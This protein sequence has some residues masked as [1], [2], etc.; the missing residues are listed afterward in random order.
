MAYEYFSGGEKIVLEPD[1]DLVAVRFVEP[2]LYSVR[3]ATA[4]KPEIDSF[5]NR[6]EVPE[7]KFTILNVAK[8]PVPR[9]DR[10]RRAVDAM[11]AEIQVARVTPVFKVGNARVLATDRVRVGFKPDTADPD[12]LIVDGGYE[13]LERYQNEYTIRIKETDDPFEVCDQFYKMAEVEYAEPD[14]VTIKAHTPTRLSGDDP[15]PLVGRQYAARITK[16]VE[17][18][19]LVEGCP[20][21]KIAILDE[22]VDTLHE[23]LAAA[24]VGSYDAVDNDTYQEPNP[25][26]GHGTACAGLAAA[27]PGNA[28]GIRG[29]GGG[30]SILAVRIAFSKS[31]G[32][33]W[34]SRDSW[35]QRAI[36]WAWQNG[37][38]VISNSWGGGLPS[39]GIRNAFDRARSTGRNG[40]GCVIVAAAGNDNGPVCFPA[41][42]P[43]VLTV[44]ASNE[45]D[46][47]K[48]PSSRDGENWWG[49]NYGPEVDVAAP[50][51]H[52]AT[53]D[54]TGEKGYNKATKGNYHYSFNGTS[55]STPIVAGAAGLMLC[56]NRNLTESQVR[57]ILLDTADKVGPEPYTHGRND[58]MGYGRLNV[59]GAVRSA[60]NID[61]GEDDGDDDHRIDPSPVKIRVT[62]SKLNV[63]SGPGVR[64]PDIGDL[65]ADQVTSMINLSG[66]DVWIRFENGKWAAYAYNGRY[67]ELSPDKAAAKVRIRRLIIRNGPGINYSQVGFLQQ[68]ELVDILDISGSDVWVE[69][70][71]TKWVAFAYLGSR[72][73]EVV[74]G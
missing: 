72:Y 55:S 24:I 70:E 44:S 64:F 59:V 58:R 14:F 67:M 2:A 31:E 8:T 40:K 9:R 20:E 39:T 5:T 51:V 29:I 42:L 43:G 34:V 30:C 71:P 21:V 1:E 65:Y 19:N 46:E 61:R 47:P 16:A 50:G 37:A 32:G 36:D 41:T 45:Y 66:N 35:I 62:A 7:E 25:W 11:K 28:L 54:I 74:S 38:D 3:S 6:L 26:D 53:T 69:F 10:F 4:E 68:G 60:L 17:A 56:A 48:T 27:I 57:K 13:V 22:G 49:S 63:R 18:W 52:N 15:D 73:M 23:D 33:N 12:R